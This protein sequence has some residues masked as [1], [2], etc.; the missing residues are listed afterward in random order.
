MDTKLGRAVVVIVLLDEAIVS[1]EAVMEGSNTKVPP[2]ATVRL[3]SSG[4]APA[5]VTRSV[6][7][8]TVVPPAYEFAADSVKLPVPI[9]VSPSGRRH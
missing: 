7:A 8:K 6:P 4:K 5:T 1:L 3:L 2:A 9:F